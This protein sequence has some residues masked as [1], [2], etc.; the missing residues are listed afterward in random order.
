MWEPEYKSEGKDD[1]N[2]ICFIFNYC[3]SSSYMRLFILIWLNPEVGERGGV[4]PCS[5]N[6]CKLFKHG[7]LFSRLGPLSTEYNRTMG[8]AKFI[9]RLQQVSINPR[10][11]ASTL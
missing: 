5:P 2:V 4:S 7:D 10:K 1:Q 8:N 6:R 9:P 11:L 3:I